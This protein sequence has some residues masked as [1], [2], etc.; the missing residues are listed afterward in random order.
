MQMLSFIPLADIVVPANRIR[1]EFD[2]KLLADLADSIASKGLLHPLVLRS[3]GRGLLAGERRLKAMSMLHESGR[4][5]NCNGYTVEAPLVPFIL[6]ND[7]SELDLREAE[8]EENTKR[9]DLSWQERA[10]AVG[11][12]H[13]LRQSQHLARGAEW[14]V[15]D[16]TRELIDESAG[17]SAAKR[18]ANTLRLAAALDDPEIA[19]AP[20][21]ASA[22]KLLWKKNDAAHRAQLASQ[23]DLSRT[24]HTIRLGDAFELLHEVEPGSV[25]IIITDPPY[26]LDADEFGSQ[27]G[28]DH[29][30]EDTQSYAYECYSMVINHSI[31]I[32]RPN[33]FMFL[34]CDFDMFSDLRNHVNGVGDWTCFRTPLIWSKTGGMLPWPHNGPRRTYECILYAARGDRRFITAGP[35]D[36]I[37]V[38]RIAR[39]DFGAEKPAELYADL[40]KWV[41]RPGDVILDPFAG[42]GPVINAASSLSCRAIAFERDAAKYNFILSN[43]L[44]ETK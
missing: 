6:V 35:S 29:S 13:S 24:P 33:A 12:L 28:A 43:R 2:K 41:A 5:F 27:A 17:G 44:G 42:T 15:A 25:D 21:E 4:N 22:L 11:E 26:G 14:T 34:F 1:K 32:C 9:A 20:D 7:L 10:A 31:S 36:V 8:L 38:S 3:D 16:L 30:Y 40:L 37:D 18:T 39:P 23:F 19:A